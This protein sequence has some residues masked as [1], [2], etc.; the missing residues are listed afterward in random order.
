MIVDDVSFDVIYIYIYIYCNHNKILLLYI[1]INKSINQ[2]IYIYN[3]QITSP[4]PTLLMPHNVMCAQ[5]CSQ[6][7]Q[8]CAS[9]SMDRSSSSSSCSII[10]IISGTGL[11]RLS[12]IYIY[13]Y[14]YICMLSRPGLA[15]CSLQ[16]T[17]TIHCFYTLLCNNCG[18]YV[19]I[20][21]YAPI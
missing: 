6:C 8:T 4:R 1:I 15:N 5:A 11:P 21:N 18:T 16:S 14:I 10:I 2:S 17:V 9:A 7:K 13:I 3:L 19:C 12:D 20:Q